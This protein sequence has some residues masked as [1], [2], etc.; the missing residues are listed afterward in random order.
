MVFRESFNFGNF[1]CD[2]KV[3]NYYNQNQA[4][5]VY[6]RLWIANFLLW[7]Y[8]LFS[9]HKVHAVLR[10]NSSILYF[11]HFH[12]YW[13]PF[14]HVS[15]WNQRSVL[16]G[17]NTMH[18]N[19]LLFHVWATTMGSASSKGTGVLMWQFVLKFENGWPRW[20]VKNTF[21]TYCNLKKMLEEKKDRK[22][23]Y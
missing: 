15:N 23:S 19:Q 5:F 14:I 3:W 11:H 20:S 21:L 1:W 18:Y 7:I 17:K 8:A 6:K 12:R 13:F 22:K 2:S 10:N 9:L 4:L 16:A